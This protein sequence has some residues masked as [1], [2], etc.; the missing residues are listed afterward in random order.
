M[1][2]FLGVKPFGT[3]SLSS[4]INAGVLAMLVGLVVV[5]IVSLFTKKLD[6]AMVDEIFTCYAQTVT[7]HSTTSLPEDVQ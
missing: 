1:V 7:V 3:V 2:S 4:P 5:P 6:G